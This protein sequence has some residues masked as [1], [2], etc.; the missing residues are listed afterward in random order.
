MATP[1]SKINTLWQAIGG[2]ILAPIL[3]MLLIIDSFV[4]E[5]LTTYETLMWLN[6]AFLF[7]HEFE[8]YILNPDGLK[9]FFNQHSGFATKPKKTNKPI[10]EKVI[11]V[12]NGCAWVWAI[13]AALFA[14]ALPWL[15]IGFLI[16]NSLIN[17]FAHTV[18]F[19]LSHKSYNPGLITVVFLFIPLYTAI[20]WYSIAFSVL[21]AGSWAL[22]IILGIGMTLF[23]S[24]AMRSKMMK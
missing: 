18:L 22:A 12:V 3:V 17:C 9:H 15:G 8:D 21:S 1:L 19:Q 20:L 24:S 5:Y 11:L 2:T 4:Y 7:F 16:T 10:S 14:N 13:A 6:L 23:M